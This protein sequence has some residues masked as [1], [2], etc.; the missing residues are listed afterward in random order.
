MLSLASPVKN[1]SS[2]HPPNSRADVIKDGATVKNGWAAE[3]KDRINLLPEQPSAFIDKFL[4]CSIPFPDDADHSDLEDAF[5]DYNPG[6][7]KEVAEYAN[8]VG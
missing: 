2:P 1:K 7:G 6:P 8:L 3:L 5:K 4:P